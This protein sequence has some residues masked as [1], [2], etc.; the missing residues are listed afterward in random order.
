MDFLPIRAGFSGVAGTTL[1]LFAENCNGSRRDSTTT[2][3]GNS[4]LL[5]SFFSAKVLHS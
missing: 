4:L 2:R 3:D 1:V 5:R